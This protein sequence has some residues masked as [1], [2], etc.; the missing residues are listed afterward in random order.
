[1]GGLLL[2][3]AAIYAGTGKRVELVG[4]AFTGQAISEKASPA[5]GIY[6]VGA[7]GLIAVFAGYAIATN[8]G[9]LAPADSRETKTCPDCAETVLSAARVCKHCGHQF[10]SETRPA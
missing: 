4:V 5:I 10:V 2:I 8:R 7:A 6:A 9:A 3:A 1:V